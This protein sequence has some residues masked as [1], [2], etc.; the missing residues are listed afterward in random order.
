MKYARTD[1]SADH[2]R[3]RGTAEHLSQTRGVARDIPAVAFQLVT[4][5]GFLDCESTRLRKADFKES[6][7]STCTHWLC[8]ALS[9]ALASMSQER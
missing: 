8:T 7:S 1:G 3:L 5:R 4:A 9:S 2:L 6:K